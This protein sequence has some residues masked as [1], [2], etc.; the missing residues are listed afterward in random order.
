MFPPYWFALP[1]AHTSATPHFAL[2]AAPT[3]SIDGHLELPGAQAVRSGVIPFAGHKLPLPA[4][5]WQEL[6]LAQ[7]SGAAAVQVELLARVENQKLTGLEM[8]A[9][10][11]PLSNSIGGFEGAGPCNATTAIV[12]ERIPVLGNNPLARECWALSEIDMTGKDASIRTDEVINRGLGRLQ[13]LGIQVPDR[14]MV[15]SYLRSDETGW[16]TAFLFLPGRHADP[17]KSLIN[18]VRRFAPLLHKGWD[19]TLTSAELASLAHDPA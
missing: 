17:K 6:A 1:A 16:M 13:Q 18:W 5:S 9:A 7:A 4:G 15:L 12:Q 10:P 11:S 8:A 2:P 3:P 14:M 19:S